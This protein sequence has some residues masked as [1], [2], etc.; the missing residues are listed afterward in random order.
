MKSLTLSEN[1]GV[2]IQL[3]PLSFLSQQRRIEIKEFCY[4]GRTFT[5]GSIRGPAKYYLAK[6]VPPPPLTENYSAKETLA[7]FGSILR[8][9]YYWNFCGILQGASEI[10]D[11]LI[12][13]LKVSMF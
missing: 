7:E 2:G 10:R 5:E 8:A 3:F 13:M 11:N 9:S 1:S 4:K 6:G 12:H